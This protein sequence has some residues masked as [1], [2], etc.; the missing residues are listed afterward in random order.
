MEPECLKSVG[1]VVYKK[2]ATPVVEAKTSSSKYIRPRDFL[3][4]Q[5]FVTAIQQSSSQDIK[6]QH[7][8]V[9]RIG[10]KKTKNIW[11]KKEGEKRN[12]EKTTKKE[13]IKKCWRHSRELK[14]ERQI[15][16]SSFSLYC[17]KLVAFF[18]S[19]RSTD[20]EEFTFSYFQFTSSFFCDLRMFGSTIRL[21]CL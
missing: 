4:N 14:W 8:G 11:Q 15:S 1:K 17:S 19:F 18:S 21:W 7:H 5:R 13:D 3:I 9:S 2:V 20:R 6:K 12:E 10:T 16:A